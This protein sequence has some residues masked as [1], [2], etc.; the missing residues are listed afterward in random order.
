MSRRQICLRTHVLT[1]V[2]GN[3]IAP[4][5]L[6]Q[7]ASIQIL[8]RQAE[9]DKVRE[10]REELAIDPIVFEQNAQSVNHDGGVAKPMEEIIRL[11]II[12]T[13]HGR[14]DD[15]AFPRSHRLREAGPVLDDAERG[16]AAQHGGRAV[17][18]LTLNPALE[19][20]HQ[21]LKLNARSPA[22][23]SGAFM[24]NFH[25]RPVRWFSIITTIG[26]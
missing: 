7:G 13:Q 21:R 4:S 8:Q 18:I 23:I 19:R 5:R 20:L 3:R 12:G 26:P 22:W 25:K 9:A 11:R 2:G 10:V 15:G 1:K 14:G 17:P 24:N 6:A 16:D